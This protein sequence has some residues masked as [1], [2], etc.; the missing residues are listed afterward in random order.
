MSVDVGVV[1][2]EATAAYVALPDVDDPLAVSS[3]VRPLVLALQPHFS[4]T[5]RC[6]L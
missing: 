1:S 3:L 6:D 5:E 4:H 2:P